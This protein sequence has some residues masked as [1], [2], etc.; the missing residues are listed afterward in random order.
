MTGVRNGVDLPEDGSIDAGLLLLSLVTPP[1]HERTLEEIAIAC[2]YLRQKI[3]YIEQQ[4]LKKL[5][6]EFER[7]GLQ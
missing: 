2:G 6:V 4:A 7:R 3:Y 5:R 1:G